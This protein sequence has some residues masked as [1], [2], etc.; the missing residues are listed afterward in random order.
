MGQHWSANGRLLSVGRA[1]SIPGSQLRLYRRGI[2]AT[3]NKA[4]GSKLVRREELS[5]GRASRAPHL[6]P[7][8]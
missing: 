3:I 4:A 5:L 2:N 1:Y 6:A 8:V 7:T